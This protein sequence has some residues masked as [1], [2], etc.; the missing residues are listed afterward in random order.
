MSVIADVI[1]LRPVGNPADVRQARYFLALLVDQR[2]E[3]SVALRTE[4]RAQARFRRSGDTEAARESRRTVDA[5]TAEARRIDEL[6]SAL[7]KRLAQPAPA[8]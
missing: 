1:A 3:L 5:L 8:D 4:R 2:S 7:K 6:T